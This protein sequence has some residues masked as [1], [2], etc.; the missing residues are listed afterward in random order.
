MNGL[1]Y[2]T[3]LA[4]YI[5]VAVLFLA[6][7]RVAPPSC[8]GKAD[9]GSSII[10]YPKAGAEV[11]CVHVTHN[12]AQND[13]MEMR[14]DCDVIATQLRGVTCQAA[15]YFFFRNGRALRN[16]PPNSAYGSSDGNVSTGVSLRS[17]LL[18]VHTHAGAIV[19][20]WNEI[21]SSASS[22]L[23][24]SEGLETHAKPSSLMSPS[25]RPSWVQ[26]RVCSTILANPPL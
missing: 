8:G 16:L 11:D 7:S 15:A 1:K 26:S 3:P 24:N 21:G 2:H 18:G 5:A 20:F 13:R 4:L 9:C 17:T 23:S 6:P 22:H 25:S 14:I 10:H 12:Q 19:T